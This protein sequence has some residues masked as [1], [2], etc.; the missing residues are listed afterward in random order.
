MIE[1]PAKRKLFL[2]K[3]EYKTCHIIL[4]DTQEA[5]AA[6]TDHRQLFSFFKTVRDREKALDILG[7]LYDNGSDAIITQTPKAYAIWILEENAV[8][9]KRTSF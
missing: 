6:I 5:I 4:S 9:T 7:K 3:G 1:A 2:Q 8:L